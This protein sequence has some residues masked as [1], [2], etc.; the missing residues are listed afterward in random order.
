[1]VFVVVLVITGLVLQEVDFCPGQSVRDVTTH[2]LT[3]HSA[4]P[5]L[6]HLGHDPGE[7]Y[8][9]RFVMYVQLTLSCSEKGLG[10]KIYGL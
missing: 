2:K 6:F 5:L 3:N 4:Q 9:M 10:D 7:K 1:M 8:V